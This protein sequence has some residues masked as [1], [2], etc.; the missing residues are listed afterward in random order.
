MTTPLQQLLARSFPSEIAVDGQMRVSLRMQGREVAVTVSAL[1]KRLLV[2]A[3]VGK[4]AVVPTTGGSAVLSVDSGDGV[5]VDYAVEIAASGA[6]RLVLR[7][8]GAPLVLRRRV[9]RD[10]ALAEALGLPAGK[11]ASVPVAA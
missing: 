6:K 5:R 9:V 8:V 11:A 7:M 2:V 4:P 3:L 1:A 10:Q